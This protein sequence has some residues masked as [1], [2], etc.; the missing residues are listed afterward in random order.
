MR[1][2]PGGGLRQRLKYYRQVIAGIQG[3]APRE[4]NVCGY[5][6]KFRGHGLPPRFDARC[7]QCGTVERHRLFKLWL[8]GHRSV[9]EGARV[10]HF[11]P[12]AALTNLIKPVAKEYVTTDI[13]PGRA[14]I[15]LNI[16]AID[17]PDASFDAVVCSHVLEHVNDR[18]ALAELFRILRPGG[19]AVLLVPIAEGWPRTYED[20]KIVSEEDRTIH[21]GLRDHVRYYGADFCDRVTAAGFVVDEFTA[22]GA[23]SVRH[24][25]MYGD[26]IFAARRP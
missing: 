3:V 16:E 5:R 26:K 12:E 20:P 13:V 22:D 25:L 17:L 11:A 7:P 14:D 18:K 6:G 21:F 2:L 19:T 24:S 15:V 9:F 10:L 8:D 23:T 1:F 4:C